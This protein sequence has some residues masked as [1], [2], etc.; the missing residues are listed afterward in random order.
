MKAF[1]A[2]LCLLPLVSSAATK[3]QTCT[4]TPNAT[5]NQLIGCPTANVIWGPTKATDLVRVIESGNVQR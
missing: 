4:T 3:I 1:W 5:V 2:L